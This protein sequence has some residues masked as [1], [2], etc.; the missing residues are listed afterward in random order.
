MAV[1]LTRYEEVK[2][3]LHIN[4]DVSSTSKKHFLDLSSLTAN[5]PK[6]SQRFRR[7]DD[8]HR[9]LSALKRSANPSLQFND[10]LKK[11]VALQESLEV[12]FCKCRTNVLLL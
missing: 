1:E 3:A 11:V 5:L 12:L 4:V 8:S 6:G 9:L 7:Y 10:P 2:P